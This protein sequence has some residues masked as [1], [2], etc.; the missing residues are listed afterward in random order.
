MK[1]GFL[2]GIETDTKERRVLMKVE[3]I[4]SHIFEMYGLSFETA[5]RAGGWTNAVWLNGDL[6]LRLSLKKD[7]DRIRREVQLSLMFPSIVGYPVNI[8]TGVIEGYEWSISKR[9]KGI[10][11]SEAW[12]GL[13][14]AER[15]N[16]IKQIREIIQG[17][18][19]VDTSKVKDL[20][21][22]NP[23]YSSLD[24]Y[25]T[26]SRFK[27]Y[28]EEGIFT[29][30]QVEALLEILKRFWNKLPT[31][32][33]V[34]NHGDIT[35]DNLLW[36]EGRI[37]S[38]MDFEHSV[39]TP[40]ELDLQS[41]INLALFSQENNLANDCNIQEY[42]QYKNDVIELIRPMLTNSH[43]ADL[44]LGFAILYRQRFL[45]FWLEDPRGELEKLDAYNK[46][47]SL[48]DGNL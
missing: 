47:C 22:R 20:S 18:H 48:A 26:L 40:S 42:L 2:G 12:P 28:S 8:S 30:E 38:L 5:S 32:P 37:V 39:I 23:W 4:A 34:L 6:A 1:I 17:V 24:A 7:T 44:I 43:S 10:N 36:C 13:T 21:S 15:T 16:A 27:Y 33:H 46:L 14:W 31:A 35:M 3:K 19:A 9:I 41:L 25:E 11:L 45:E 29:S